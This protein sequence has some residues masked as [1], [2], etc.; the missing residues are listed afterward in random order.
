MTAPLRDE[1]CWLYLFGVGITCSS[2]TI[3]DCVAEWQ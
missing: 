1:L 2:S 3:L